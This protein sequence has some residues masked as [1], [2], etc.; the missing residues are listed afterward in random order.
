MKAAGVPGGD[1][2][3]PRGGALHKKSGHIPRHHGYKWPMRTTF[4]RFPRFALILAL[5]AA[6]GAKPPKPEIPPPPPLV[7]PPPV[8]QIATGP[9]LE[10]QVTPSASVIAADKPAEVFVRLRLKGLALAA[11][12]RP[13]INLALVVDTSGSMVGAAI[14]KARDACGSLIDALEEGDALSIVTFGSEPQVIVPATRI[15]RETQAR[16]QEAIRTIKADGT[17]NM[18]GGLQV[19]IAQA[20]TFLTP[21]GV[22]RIVLVGDGVPNEPASVVALADQAQLLHLPVTTLGLGAEFDETLM[23]VVA[24]RSG[25]TFHFIADASKVAQVLKDEMLRM[26]RVVARGVWLDMTPGPGVV[27]DEVLGAEPMAA[28][29]GMRVNVGEIGEGQVRDVVVRVTATGHHDGSSVELLDTV[30]HYSHAVDGSALIVRQF[31]ALAASL[32]AEAVTDGKSMEIEHQAARLR[33]ATSIVRAIALARS[34]DVKG[35]R[36]LLDVTTKLATQAAARFEDPELLAKAK[37]AQAIKKTVASLAPPPTPIVGLNGRPPPPKAGGR[38]SAAPAPPPSP[39]EALVMKSA[40]G[41]AMK[42]LQG[43]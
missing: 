3:R 20:R 27:I 5:A 16:A 35:A 4:L 37:E 30:A 11:T 33:V 34:G 17:T 12:K 43:N 40:H 9:T 25:G 1:E 31:L 13:P 21:D 10:L 32:D 38:P 19:G 7:T 39:A 28:G 6:C 36:A 2:A 15:T 26:E 23:L 8:V 14:E 18:A 22:S 42:E 29:R 24:R 41:D